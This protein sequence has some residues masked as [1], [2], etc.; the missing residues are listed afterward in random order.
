MKKL[1][2]ITAL[3]ALTLMSCEKKQVA[4]DS[5]AK[6]NQAS[7]IE[8]SLK[9]QNSISREFK[10]GVH[11]TVLQKPVPTVVTNKV[12]VVEIFAYSCSH[13][14]DFEVLLNVWKDYF[15]PDMAFLHM[16]VAWSSEMKLHSKAFFTAQSLG[17]LGQLHQEIFDTIH[18]NNNPLNSEKAIAKLFAKHGIDEE[19]FLKEFNGKKTNA[20]VDIANERAGQYNVQGTPSLII[21]G[22]YLISA[23]REVSHITMIE[24]AVF[25]IDKVRKERLQTSSSSPK[26]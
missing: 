13:C 18:K 23:S 10:E 1:L 14:F 9:Q 2:I 20:Q 24:V 4:K 8:D 16:P 12:E 7:K 22:K 19:L 26:N 15:T 5:D 3:F 6:A 11:Y 21:D 25:L 17:V